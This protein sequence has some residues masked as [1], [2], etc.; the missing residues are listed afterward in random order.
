MKYEGPSRVLWPNVVLRI[1]V[2]LANELETIASFNAVSPSRILTMACM[3]LTETARRSE[4]P[5]PTASG[6]GETE[7][8]VLRAAEADADE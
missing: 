3:R 1:P 4:P 5:A 2:D 6:Y 8:E 7:E